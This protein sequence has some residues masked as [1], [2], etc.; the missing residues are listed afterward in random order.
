MFSRTMFGVSAF[1]VAIAASFWPSAPAVSGESPPQNEGSAR[2]L[3]IKSISYT[4][5]SK[6]MSG[7]FVQQNSVC[8]VTLMIIERSD[9]DRPSP[10]TA[11]R[12]RIM[13]DPGQVAG[14]DSEEGRSLNFTCGE[15]AA[16]LV[17]D[18]GERSKLVARQGLAVT[19]TIA[20][21]VHGKL[22]E[23]ARLP[24]PMQTSEED[25][26]GRVGVCTRGVSLSSCAG[27]VGDRMVGDFSAPL[28]SSR[29]PRRKRTRSARSSIGSLTARSTRGRITAIGATMRFASTA[30]GRTA[31]AHRL[32]LRWSTTS[33]ISKLSGVSCMTAKAVERRS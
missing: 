20:E 1:V 2:Y 4:L 14:L 25:C 29:A 11:A 15:D 13:L 30:T 26:G 5:G 21:R 10:S 12:V 3:P 22:A 24:L 33:L 9:S 8:L 28:P 32:A 16:T 7:Y 27:A 18:Y 17:V 23:L 31:W 6:A 19:N